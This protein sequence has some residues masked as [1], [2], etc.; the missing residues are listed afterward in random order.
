MTKCCINITPLDV[1]R[2]TLQI[3]MILISIENNSQLQL[4]VDVL[5]MFYFLTVVKD[6]KNIDK[7]LL[8]KIIKINSNNKLT[9]KDLTYKV[10]IND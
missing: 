7:T 10:F 4:K 5:I 6:F 8:I 3:R 9:Q 2:E 1:S